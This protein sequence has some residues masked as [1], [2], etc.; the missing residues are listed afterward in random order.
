MAFAS[1]PLVLSLAVAPAQPAHPKT[2][3]E[4]ASTYDQATCATLDGVLADG[5]DR[6]AIGEDAPAPQLDDDCRPQAAPVADCNDPQLGKFSPWVGEMI[7]TCDMPRPHAH[8]TLRALRA[9]DEHRAQRLLAELA[10]QSDSA[11]PLGIPAPDHDFSPALLSANL[12][13]LMAP[14]P[15]GVIHFDAPR[16]LRSISLDGLLRPPRA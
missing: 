8:P 3:V 13:A 6:A 2:D 11:A 15:F 9:H 4:L 7:G 16:A 12:A 5:W 10:S 14:A 1:I